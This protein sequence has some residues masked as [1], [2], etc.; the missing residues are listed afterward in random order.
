MTSRQ[1]QVWIGDYKETGQKRQY[2]TIKIN[3]SPMASCVR[4]SFWTEE[5]K[6]KIQFLKKEYYLPTIMSEKLTI[7][8]VTALWL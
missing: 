3:Y 2:G 5:F 6:I 4:V 1:I 8:W 7:G